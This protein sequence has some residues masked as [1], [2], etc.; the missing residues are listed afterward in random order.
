M[1]IVLAFDKTG[2]GVFIAGQASQFVWLERIAEIGKCLLDQ[3][4]TLLPIVADKAFGVDA[5]WPVN[6]ND[7]L[8]RGWLGRIAQVA[9]QL[10]GKAGVT[11]GR[12]GR[13]FAPNVVR[14]W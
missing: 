7:G 6:I 14:E 12:Q 11:G 10:C 4:R 5:R 13:Q 8:L 3:Q 2:I 9:R 1:T